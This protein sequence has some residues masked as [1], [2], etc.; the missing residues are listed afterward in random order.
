[1]SRRSEHDCVDTSPDRKPWLRS[2]SDRLLPSDLGAGTSAE[3][4]EERRLLCR[5]GSLPMA[6]APKATGTFMRREPAPFPRACSACSIGQV[7]HL[8]R[9]A[10]RRVRRAK[11]CT[12]TSVLREVRETATT[13]TAGVL[14]GFQGRS[15]GCGKCQGKMVRSMNMNNVVEMPYCVAHPKHRPTESRKHLVRR[16]RYAMRLACPAPKPM[17]QRST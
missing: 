1:M 8:L 15:T 4:E 2:L 17:I 6:R 12:S 11:A 16:L 7:G 5:S 3:I 9:S 14:C 13:S 10:L